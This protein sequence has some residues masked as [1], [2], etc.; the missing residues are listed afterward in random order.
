MNKQ[1]S[2]IWIWIG[3][4]VI[5]FGSS[6]DAYTLHSL[7]ANIDSY[8]NV[9]NSLYS[10]YNENSLYNANKS[11]LDI[12]LNLKIINYMS[13]VS[14][15]SLMGLVMLK[16]NSNKNINNIYIW[17]IFIILILTLAFSAYTYNDLYTNIDNYVNTYINTRK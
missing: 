10:N 7:C 2:V 3:F 15:I 16:F 5:M 11:I 14:I 9:H 17:L 8:I 4:V 13:I 1:I 6:L 12:L